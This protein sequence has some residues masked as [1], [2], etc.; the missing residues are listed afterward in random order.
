[1]NVFSRH[2]LN[3][4]FISM[5]H[6]S[7]AIDLTCSIGIATSD[8]LC[9]LVVVILHQITR[10]PQYGDVILLTIECCHSIAMTVW[11]WSP[12]Q[13][14]KIALSGLDCLFAIVLSSSLIAY[15]STISEDYSPWTTTINMPFVVVIWL[16]TWF[17]SLRLGCGK[18][19]TEQDQSPPE[20]APAPSF[21]SKTSPDGFEL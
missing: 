4:Q 11:I 6:R 8:F 5:Y 21:S 1:M 13:K 12:N 9:R 20:I 2:K 15:S 17:S 14:A 3:P 18:Y 7:P 19:Q 10:L 16:A